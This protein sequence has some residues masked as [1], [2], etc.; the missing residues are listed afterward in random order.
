MLARS[1][2]KTAEE[3]GLA[4]TYYEALIVVL[5]KMKSKELVWTRQDRPCPNGFN[6]AVGWN[7]FGP[8]KSC[9]T[10]GCIA[11][12]ASH[13]SDKEKWKNDK[14]VERTREQSNAWYGLVM[15]VGYHMGRHTLAQA[16]V[17]LESY[18]LMGKADWSS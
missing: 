10:V 13:F 5:E 2:Y 8:E 9:G 3:L 1:P 6:M 12:W 15:P 16:Q 7:R 14:P 4:Q 18:L 17:A 11:G